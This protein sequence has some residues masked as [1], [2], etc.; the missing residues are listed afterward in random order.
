MFTRYLDIINEFISHL[1]ELRCIHN[2]NY[3]RGVTA[4]GVETLTHVYRHLILYTKNIGLAHYN[5]KKAIYFYIEFINQI[6]DSTVTFNLTTNDAV[7]FVYKKTIFDIVHSV[8]TDYDD[9]C[10]QTHNT[11]NT[12]FYMTELYVSRFLNIIDN[13]ETLTL[14]IISVALSKSN[15]FAQQIIFM[16]HNND[17]INSNMKVKLLLKFTTCINCSNMDNK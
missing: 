11:A 15:E 14:E 9:T 16:M 5:C 4:K 8:R 6:E 12:L 13:C 1:N 17:L 2:I 7:L 10:E 3:F